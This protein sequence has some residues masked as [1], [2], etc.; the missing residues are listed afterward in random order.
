MNDD[1]NDD[2]K[3]DDDGG[4]DDPHQVL[5]IRVHHGKPCALRVVAIL[6]E[7]NCHHHYLDLIKITVH[8]GRIKIIIIQNLIFK[9]LHGNEDV[10]SWTNHTE[11]F[12]ERRGVDLA[13]VDIIQ[14]NT[15]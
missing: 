14:R 8:T 11:H 4:G 7:T 15:L 6:K 2:D 12:R 10:A 3:D 13:W 9:N 1:D 5:N